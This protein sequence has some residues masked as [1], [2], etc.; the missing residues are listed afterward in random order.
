MIE[1]LNVRGVAADLATVLQRI[2]AEGAWFERASSKVRTCYYGEVG[3]RKEQIP[4]DVICRFFGRTPTLAYP[5]GSQ[6][7]CGRIVCTGSVSKKDSHRRYRSTSKPLNSA[8]A[9]ERTCMMCR[10]LFASL[11]PGNRRCQKCE[12]SIG[13]F[14]MGK[15]SVR[16]AMRNAVR[17]V[18]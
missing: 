3:D 4:R 8:S 18:D 13:P 14:S 6:V 17:I 16:L 10:E 7:K 11:S 9:K 15:P 1:N 5:D 12:D 2:N